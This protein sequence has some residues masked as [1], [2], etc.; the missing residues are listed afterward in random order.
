MEKAGDPVLEV[1]SSGS[2]GEGR[3]SRGQ[4]YEEQ[5]REVGC[6][7]WRAVGTLLGTMGAA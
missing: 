4:H 6:L 1:E 7:G 2:G 3:A 5:R